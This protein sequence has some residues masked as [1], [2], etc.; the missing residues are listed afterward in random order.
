MKEDKLKS[1]YLYGYSGSG[2]PQIQHR[3]LLKQRLMDIGDATLVDVR[4]SPRSR[5]SGFNQ[6]P[7]EQ[8]LGSRYI[9]V[10]QL[11]NS[12]YLSGGSATIVNMKVGVQKVL[13]IIR[14]RPVV[15]MCECKPKFHLVEL[16]ETD[17]IERQTVRDVVPWILG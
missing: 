7:L 5:V 16:M 6:G 4:Y 14:E 17:H 9:H 10:P 1:V 12:S 2:I 3:S 11:G 8:L 15:L 13:D